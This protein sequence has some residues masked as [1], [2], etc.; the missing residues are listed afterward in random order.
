MNSKST[1]SGGWGV[2][3][4][5]D[6]LNSTIFNSLPTDV[7][8]KIKEVK[9]QYIQ[10]YNNPSSFAYSAD[11]LWLL[12]CGEVWNDKAR[13][14]A[15]EGKQYKFYKNLN[16]SVSA[17]SLIVKPSAKVGT[18]TGSIWWLRS[19]SASYYRHFHSVYSNR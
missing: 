3:N 18:S 10:T 12:S 5:R 16:L 19:P 17:N 8:I 6:A 13:S 7:R 9:K 4:L 1:N 11:K 15:I 14:T 2:C